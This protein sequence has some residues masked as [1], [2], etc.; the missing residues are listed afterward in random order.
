[1]NGRGHRALEAPQFDQRKNAD[2][3]ARSRQPPERQAMTNNTPPIEAVERVAR[4]IYEACPPCRDPAPFDELFPN[5]RAKFI[6][7][8]EAVLATLTPHPDQ[9]EAMS[10]V[11]ERLR[12]QIE[13]AKRDHDYIIEIETA[14]EALTA[15]T[16]A[17]IPQPVDAGESGRN[18]NVR[19]ALEDA[20]AI[21]R[22]ADEADDNNWQDWAATMR[23][24]AIH[25]R[26]ALSKGATG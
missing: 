23:C 5:A 8:A 19:L 16:A 2:G 14:E 7:Q 13:M 21:E 3:C 17:S 15:L 1:V 26:A 9:T 12:G 24:A 22:I 4:T 18:D 25:I 11:V 20:D 10:G 6:A